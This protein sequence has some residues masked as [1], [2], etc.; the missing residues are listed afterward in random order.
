MS[1]LV[2]M[3]GLVGHRLAV[4]KAEKDY[5]VAVCECGAWSLEYPRRR[6]SCST[7][8]ARGVTQSHRDHIERSLLVSSEPSSKG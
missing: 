6:D 5:G 2:F 8:T 1:T 4:E 7:E 3:N